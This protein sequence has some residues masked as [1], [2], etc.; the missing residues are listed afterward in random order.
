MATHRITVELPDEILLILGSTDA[1]AELMKEAAVM[2]LLRRA[3]ISQGKA[4]H[5]LGISRWDLPA[6]MGRYQVPSG[7]ETPE[8]VDR[9]IDAA[10][11]YLEQTRTLARH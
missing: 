8:E 7:P 4:A 5:L 2:E 11:A 6:L 10:I 9:E 3:E 1:A